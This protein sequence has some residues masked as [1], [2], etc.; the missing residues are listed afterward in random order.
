MR[1]FVAAKEGE[2]LG[3]RDLEL[4]A[5]GRGRER[6]VEAEERLAKVLGVV[7]RL[8]VRL[9]AIQGARVIS[10]LQYNNGAFD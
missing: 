5:R 2:A 9:E 1:L 10:L 8:E 3:A 7:G 4:A 6:A